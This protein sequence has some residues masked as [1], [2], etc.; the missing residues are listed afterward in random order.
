MHIICMRGCERTSRSDSGAA[1]RI[2]GRLGGVL[3]LEGTLDA[4][5]L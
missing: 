3:A 5:N 1:R 4:L 2:A